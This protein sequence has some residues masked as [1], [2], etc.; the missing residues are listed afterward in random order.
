[1]MR[2]TPGDRVDWKWL[3]GPATWQTEFGDPLGTTMYTACLYAGSSLRMTLEL[4]PG[5]TCGQVPC[6]SKIRDAGYHYKDNAA[7]IG[8]VRRLKLAGSQRART[9]IKLMG[10]GFALPDVTPPL[11]TPL[12]M[13][14]SRN[15]STICFE[16][17]LGPSDLKRNDDTQLQARSV[18]E[19]I[20]PLPP[21]PSGG[22]GGAIAPYTPGTSLPG[23]L[24]HQGLDRTFRVYLPGTYATANDTP[25]PIVFLLHGGFGSGAQVEESSRLIPIADGAGFVL[26]SPDGV[27]GPF[28]VRTWNAGDCCGYSVDTGVDDVGFMRALLDEL[29]GHVVP[30][31][32]PRLRGRNVER[33]HADASAGL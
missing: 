32:A 7:M 12:T 3:N 17:I 24:S 22:C 14:L 8:G 23:S 31:S 1:M 11:V 27:A 29:Q 28:G 16:S 6:W 21:L 19:P 26:V 15:Q 13:Q 5:G 20:T 18:V 2:T 25:V 33:R 10:R 30:R 9:R 4:T